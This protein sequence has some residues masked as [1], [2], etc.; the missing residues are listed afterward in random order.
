STL[1]ERH[2]P[3]VAKRVGMHHAEPDA[4]GV[5]VLPGK[6]HGILVQIHAGDL[7]GPAAQE[8]IEPES[9]GV[10][11]KIKHRAIGAKPGQ[12]AA[13]VALVAE[14]ARLVAFLE[15]NPVANPMLVDGHPGWKL[16]TGEETAR[17]VFLF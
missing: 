15:M 4:V 8:G 7:A 11:A 17:K 6:R 10:A 12:I 2:L 3:H 16:R 5:A 13:V 14:E 9:A 1:I